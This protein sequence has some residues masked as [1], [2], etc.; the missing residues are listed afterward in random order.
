M[1]LGN[2][3]DPCVSMVIFHGNI[4]WSFLRTTLFVIV[5]KHHTHHHRWR[6]AAEHHDSHS[7]QHTESPCRN[8]EIRGPTQSGTSYFDF[9][10]HRQGFIID[11]IS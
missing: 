10:V 2:S 7:R 8:G 6:W 9:Y 3:Y 11:R 5:H 1:K 4:H